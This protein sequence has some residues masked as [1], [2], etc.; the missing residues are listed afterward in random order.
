M[1]LREQG[2]PACSKCARPPLAAW[3]APCA[4]LAPFPAPPLYSLTSAVFCGMKAYVQGDVWQGDK[5]EA[6]TEL[7]EK[8]QALAELQK[9][10]QQHEEGDSVWALWPTRRCRRP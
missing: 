8:Q 3:P 7:V 6:N 5:T 10:Q 1:R 4:Q 2:M 9:Q